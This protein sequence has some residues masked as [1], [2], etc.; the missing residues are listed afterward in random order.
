MSNY[1]LIKL[2]STINNRHV[3]IAKSKSFKI[4]HI[5]AMIILIG[6]L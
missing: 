4:Y 2:L 5:A 3:K 1:M 6:E